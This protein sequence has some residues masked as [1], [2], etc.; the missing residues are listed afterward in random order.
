MQC[1]ELLLRASWPDLMY[2]AAA[3]VAR[4]PLRPFASLI[5]ESKIIYI[6]VAAPQ[7]IEP[8]AG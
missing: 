5:R 2:P 4:I 7:A 6:A 8:Y 3:L 1:N